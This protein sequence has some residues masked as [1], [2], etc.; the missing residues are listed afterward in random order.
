MPDDGSVTAVILNLTG[1][2]AA[3]TTFVQATPTGT[4]GTTSSLNLLP[5]QNKANLAMVPLSADGRAHFFN[6]FG[7]MQLI[8][9]V[10][11]YYQ[12]AGTDD[13]SRAGRVVPLASPFR[14]IET[15]A[16]GGG[17]GVKL[18]PGPGGHVGL[19]ALR[20]ARCRT[21]AAAPSGT[22][23]GWSSTSPPPS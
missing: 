1:T 19:P 22:C 12:K 21:P 6:L 15:R 10:V 9:D 23:P 7:P 18:G 8:A 16:A 4:S 11:G 13:E 17:D 2:E 3:R 5:G 20:V 14:A